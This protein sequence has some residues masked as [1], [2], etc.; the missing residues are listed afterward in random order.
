MSKEKIKRKKHKKRKEH[1]EIFYEWVLVVAFG[2]FAFLISILIA[3]ESV[4]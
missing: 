1:S 3:M 2:L 4:K